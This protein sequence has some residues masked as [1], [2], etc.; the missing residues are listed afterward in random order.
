[1]SRFQISGSGPVGLAPN[2]P[3][4]DKSGLIAEYMRHH[5]IDGDLA[6]HS[7]LDLGD[8]YR[9]VTMHGMPIYI[10]HVGKDELD[11]WVQENTFS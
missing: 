10:Y 9:A 5:N 2:L 1:M 3:L 11:K 6:I 4:S 8:H 7:T